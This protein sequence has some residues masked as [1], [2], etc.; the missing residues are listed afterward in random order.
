MPTY[1]E[2]LNLKSFLESDAPEIVWT[3]AYRT[4]VL[5]KCGIPG[6]PGLFFLHLTDLSNSY[7]L[8]RKSEIV[9][10]WEPA[11][12]TLWNPCYSLTYSR[13]VVNT[14]GLK[15]RHTSAVL[16]VVRNQAECILL[17]RVAGAP[18]PS[19]KPWMPLSEWK[20]T[21][22]ACMTVHDCFMQRKKPS[23][24]CAVVVREDGI[25]WADAMLLITDPDALAAKLADREAARNPEHINARAEYA[26]WIRQQLAELEA[27]PTHPLYIRRKIAECI[28]PEAMHSVRLVIVRDDL[29]VDTRIDADYISRLKY[30]DCLYS[31]WL[32][33]RSARVLWDTHF[34]NESIKPEDIACINY[35]RKRLYT[36]EENA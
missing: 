16:E 22:E 10:I 7:G 14:D 28:D 29:R 9:A 25:E 2:A 19:E 36:K 15:L 3:T 26:P 33:D 13:E 30:N 34:K 6:F 8:P 18:L 27:D 20:H 31:H 5:H 11:A 21:R 24:G 17:A 12:S 4:N 23:T 1:P 35:G 32:G